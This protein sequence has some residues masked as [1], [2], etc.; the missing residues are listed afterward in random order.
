MNNIQ[1]DD[2]EELESQIS[3]EEDPEKKQWMKFALDMILG[4]KSKNARV[5][6]EVKEIDKSLRTA[7]A[8]VLNF[9]AENEGQF[10]QK[11]LEDVATLIIKRSKLV[12]NLK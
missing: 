1:N 4:K 9:Y 6:K 12:K 8:M 11:L 3:K 10:N 2:V 5:L 7:M